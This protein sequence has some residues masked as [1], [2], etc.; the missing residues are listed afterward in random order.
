[1]TNSLLDGTLA[2]AG[3]FQAA[4]LVRQIAHEGRVD[5]VP[6]QASIGSIFVLE[7]GDVEVVYGGR[8]GVALGLQI[9]REQFT[10]ARGQRDFEVT[11]YVVSAM[12]LERRMI[13]NAAMVEHIRINVERI[14]AQAGHFSVV[15]ENILAA[16]AELYVQTI[17]TLAPRIIVS[18]DQGHLMVAGNAER[19]RAL[20]LAAIRSAVLWRQCGGNRWQLLF[21]RKR[22]AHAARALI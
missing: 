3:I 1:M 7:P 14:R 16:L 12:H 4:H 8:H 9:V 11:K 20:L 21:G 10:E 5:E 22:L 18:G 17:S 19:V 6:F 13:K 15:H 2:L